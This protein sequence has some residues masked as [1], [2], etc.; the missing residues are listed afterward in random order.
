MCIRDRYY[1]VLLI[2]E[3][4]LIGKYIEKA[5]VWAQHVYTL[6]IVMIGWVFFSSTDLS[7]AMEYLKILF[8]M[9]GVPFANT[10]TLYLLRTNLILL[11][12]GCIAATHEP[13]KQFDILCKKNIVI[14]TIMIL[15]VLVL[16]TAY[17][18]FSSY[19][20]FLYFRF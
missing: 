20:P 11:A 8:C 3:K 13:M 18:I 9:G 16:A 4:Y 14:A 12:I 19:N 2:L 17:L 1:G 5:P 6:I 15:F 10:Y 7:A